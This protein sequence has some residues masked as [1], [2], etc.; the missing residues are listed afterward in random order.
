MGPNYLIPTRFVTES[1]GF[2]GNISA[3]KQSFTAFPISLRGSWLEEPMM[4]ILIHPKNMPSIQYFVYAE[5]FAIYRLKIFVTDLLEK[6]SYP[7][8]DDS[9]FY[10]LNSF[11]KGNLILRTFV[12]KKNDYLNNLKDQNLI[13]DYHKALD[14][15]LPET[16]WIS[17]ISIPELFWVNHHKVG[18]IIIDP[19]LFG[20]PD[21]RQAVVF[22]R[23]PNI[24]GFFDEDEVIIAETDQDK[25]HHPLI[26]P[27]ELR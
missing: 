24:L 26:T 11:D 7:Q 15:H 20:P 14:Q 13:K 9:R 4:A 12:T 10:F 17:E 16:F 8:S 19:K 22:I 21:F 23:L 3:L 5:P 2:V 6:G 1:V 27:S 25:I 18:E